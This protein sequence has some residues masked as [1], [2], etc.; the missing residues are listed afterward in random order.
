LALSMCLPEESIIARKKAIQ[1][2]SLIHKN[3]KQ[4]N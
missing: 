2:G 1:Y 3:Y 4:L